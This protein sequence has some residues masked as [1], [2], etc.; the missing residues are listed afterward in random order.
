MYACFECVHTFAHVG[1]FAYYFETI[2]SF[3]GHA[4]QLQILN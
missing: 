2:C 1:E 3:E 4:D